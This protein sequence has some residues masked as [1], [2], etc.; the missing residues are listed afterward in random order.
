MAHILAWSRR[1]EKAYR[2]N[3]DDL[4]ISAAFLRELGGEQTET[5]AVRSARLLPAGN[6]REVTRPDGRTV[7]PIIILMLGAWTLTAC[8]TAATSKE[9]ALHNE[10]FVRQ[11]MPQVRLHVLIDWSG[12]C[13]RAPLEEAWQNLRA[14]LPELLMTYGIT[15]LMIS[16]FDENGWC[17]RTIVAL[18]LPRLLVASSKPN[19]TTEW[20]SFANIRDALREQEQVKLAGEKAVAETTYR[21]KLHAALAALDAA[22][23]LPPP[24]R[25][26]RR[27]DVVGLLRR[28][29]QTHSL[30]PEYFLVLTDVADTTQRE[31]APVDPPQGEVALAVLIIP[32]EEREIV[33]TTGKALSGSDQF[34]LRARQ[35]RHALPWAVS[36]PCFARNL[37]ALFR[38]GLPAR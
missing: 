12:S 22:E 32:A 27:S 24:A 16:A 38:P 37:E 30:H 25:Q 13:M 8:T 31:L 17:P 15:N 2:K 9:T 33:A 34:E 14:E 28:V 11:A 19:L 35:L 3:D 5:A 18:E 1:Y 4:R 23:I 36:A 26:S 10:S 20:E 21:Q 6:E 7:F 29:S